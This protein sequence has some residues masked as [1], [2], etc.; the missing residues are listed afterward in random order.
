MIECKIPTPP[1]VLR[2]VVS[3]WFLERINDR[4]HVCW[5]A[6]VMWKF[7]YG[8]RWS[9]F[10]NCREGNDPCY[11]G[12]YGGPVPFPVPPLPYLKYDGM[13]LKQWRAEEQADAE[14]RNDA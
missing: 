3:W 10:T 6:L 12:K 7:G 5:A 13:T 11:C 1:S 14:D 8:W 4:F 2:H 9:D